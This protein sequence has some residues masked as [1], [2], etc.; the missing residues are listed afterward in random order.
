MSNIKLIDNNSFTKTASKIVLLNDTNN[1]SVTC[2][3][4][5]NNDSLEYEDSNEDIALYNIDNNPSELI[6]N[7][8]SFSNLAY[9]WNSYGSN[10]VC[11]K[12]INRAIKTVNIF[13]NKNVFI[14][15]A[16]PLH[17]GGVQLELNTDSYSLEI[18]LNPLGFKDQ[19]IIF[20]K[21]DN[22]VF[23]KKEAQLSIATI[24]EA[25]SNI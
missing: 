19:I 5:D 2:S 13:E 3:L 18:E 6:K 16:Y 17:D 20:D 24:E 21:N 12:C 11:L 9:N 22:I 4:N 14:K 25:V 7:I 8:I 15:F 1:F 10:K 23:E